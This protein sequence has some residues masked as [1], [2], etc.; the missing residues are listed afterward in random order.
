[1]AIEQ[2]AVFIDAGFLLAVGGSRVSGTSLRSATLVD[3]ETLIRGVVDTTVEDSGLDALRVYWYDASKDGVFHEAH[4]RIALI[5]DVKVRLGRIGVN[6]T[7]KGVDLRMGLDLVEIARNRA[8]RVAYLLT[9]D[10]DLAEA[11]EAAQDLGM[12]VV[13]V[14]LENQDHYLRVTS[15][16]EHLAMQV[17]RIITLPNE[18]ITKCFTPRTRPKPMQDG[19]GPADSPTDTTT[20]PGPGQTARAAPG[21]APPPTPPAHPIPTPLTI[22]MNG[23][24]RPHSEPAEAVA[25]ASKPSTHPPMPAPAGP[26]GTEH[27]GVAEVQRLLE[28]AAGVGRSV[29][30]SWYDTCTQSELEDVL[31]D[32]PNLPI[33]IDATLLRDCAS[34]I[35]EYD[36][37]RQSVR[38]RLRTAFWEQID[39]IH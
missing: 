9:G 18:L 14:G 6:G 4:K 23:L 33:H 12:K 15:V 11:V 17:D 3:T 32:R 30:E 35:G 8:A 13:L 2:S 10:D 21:A 26:G 27:P 25:R 34:K 24:G 16:A 20:A 38:Q 7:Q 5:D 36:T 29:A 31:T 22:R 19:T 37:D 1:M 28:V 39:L